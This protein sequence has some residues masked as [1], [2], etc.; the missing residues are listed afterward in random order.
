MYSGERCGIT[1]A[2]SILVDK[3]NEISSY[4]ARGELTQILGLKKAVGGCVPN[5]AIDLKKICP[6]LPVYAAGKIGKDEEGNF[7]LECLRQDGVDV[8]GV[9][10]SEEEKT[11]FTEVMSVING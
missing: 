7:V 6:S 3:I 11:S 10:V 9:L 5:V 4:P 2:G 8:T 1:V